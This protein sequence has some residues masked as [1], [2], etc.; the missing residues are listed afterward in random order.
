[1]GRSP[2]PEGVERPM[3]RGKAARGGRGIRSVGS[4]WIW[5]QSKP[6]FAK[7]ALYIAPCE[8]TG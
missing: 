6:V 5:F 7:I 3:V 4:S 2:Q 1:L 8:V